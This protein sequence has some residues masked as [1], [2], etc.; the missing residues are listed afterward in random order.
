MIHK[1]I[2]W[3]HIIFRGFYTREPAPVSIAGTCL[4][5]HRKLVTQSC[6]DLAN[7]SFRNFA[8]I[9][10]DLSIASILPPTGDGS[11]QCMRVRA[12]NFPL[13]D[14]ASQLKEPGQWIL[15]PARWRRWRRWKFTMFPP[16]PISVGWST[17]TFSSG[18]R[19]SRA[20]MRSTKV[21]EN[22]SRHPKPVWTSSIRSTLIRLCT[23]RELDR[24]YNLTFHAKST[25]RVSSG[26]QGSHQIASLSRTP[27]SR[28]TTP[29]H[30]SCI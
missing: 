2:F 20:V 28:H 1:N 13:V 8:V 30:Y 11:V 5:S 10:A 22:P 21:A 4:N 25:T 24:V 29:I 17:S 16:A 15:Q 7:Q 18:I 27:S 23:G 14:C 19:F 12:V 26:R 3:G 9:F 6:R